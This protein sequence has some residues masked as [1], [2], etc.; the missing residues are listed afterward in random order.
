MAKQLLTH[1]SNL[2]TTPLAPAEALRRART[3]VCEALGAEDVAVV[4]TD[5]GGFRTLGQ[6]S[7]GLTQIGFWLI[8]RDLTS[9]ATACAFDI[10]G[11]HVTRLRPATSRQ[12]CRHVA[13]LVP[14]ASSAGEMLIIQGDWRGG[15]GKERL[16]TLQAALPAIALLLE[17]RLDAARVERHQAELNALA[18]V[19][20]MIANDDD[21]ETMLTG[22]AGAIAMATDIDYVSIDLFGADGGPTLRCVNSTRPGTDVLR[23]RWRAGADRPDP[24]RDEVMATRRPLLFPDA[25]NDDRIPESGRQF[26]MRTLIQSTGTFPLVA[27]G[28]VLG[29][30]SVA[31]HHP[32]RFSEQQVELLEG[33]ANQV[34]LTVL[35]IRLYQ[36]LAAS[37]AEL[38]RLNEQLLESM[39]IE[40][41]LARTDALTGIPNRRFID[42]TIE[43]ECARARRYGLALSV[44]AADVDHLKDVNDRY[45]H[46]AG[47]EA[48]RRVASLARATCRQVD[49][50]GRYGGDEF[51][52][53]LPATPLE[54]A[55][56]FAE[57][58]RQALAEQTG[59]DGSP[60]VPALTVS[61]G[62]A[63]WDNETMRETSCLIAVA[64]RA[65]Y[66]AK[67]GGRD[68]V[69]VGDVTAHAA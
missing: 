47:D 14:M 43:A 2:T 27:R 34:A 24:V 65:M 23:E 39:G 21:A 50:V 40:H 63:A 67:A 37:K 32:L 1:L 17:R 41:H 57:R 45:G 18:N 30:L 7:E 4:Y 11:E 48:L 49:I 51:V 6:V 16:A 46:P 26:F 13:I 19:S 55:V 60:V 28:E 53:V 56:A 15:F 54:D 64:D 42:E 33:L 10:D 8:H 31:S 9:R 12:R 68:R 58:Y 61:L 62:V 69:V 3:I 52:F 35:S 5:E 66:A 59:K 22:I 20:K 29:V 44:V 25:Q 38:E 36:E